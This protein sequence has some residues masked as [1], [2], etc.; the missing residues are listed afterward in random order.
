MRSRMIGKN[1]SM[2]NKWMAFFLSLFIPGTGLATSRSRINF[3]FLSPICLFV[4][5]PA[6]TDAFQTAS[7]EPRTFTSDSIPYVLFMLFAVG[8]FAVPLLWLSP[9]FSGTSK[10]ILTALVIVIAIGAILF[11]K[12]VSSMMSAYLE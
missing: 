4:M 6:A 11:L 12:E 1:E 8:P 9:K 3:L 7:G 5:I 2:K 10:I